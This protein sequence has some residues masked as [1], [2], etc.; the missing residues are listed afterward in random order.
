LTD[1]IIL[2]LNR[3]G[4]EEGYA[5]PIGWLIGV[6]IIIILA[7]IAN[8]VVKRI[9][10]KILQLVVKGSKSDWDD[11]ILKRKVFHRLANLAPAL[12]IYF[13]APMF[14]AAQDWIQRIT[15]SGMALIF[16]LSLNAFAN[17]VVDI[18]NKYEISQERPIKGVVQII[19]ILAY[20]LGAVFI[21]ATLMN[22]SPWVLLS[23]IGA[24]TAILLLIF[25]DSILGFVAGMQL[26]ANRM[27]RL[28]D[29]IEMPKYGADG[30]V[31]DITLTTVKVQNWDKTISTIP[32]YA[33]ITDSFKNWRGM[34]E[35]GGR[36]IKRAIY[37]DMNSIK[38]CNRE[39]LDRFEKI[40]YLRDYIKNKRKEIE[41]YNIAHKVDT[42]TL[43][44]GRNLTNIGTFRA[45]I[46]AYLKNHPKI[47][48]D[49]TFLIR[50][51]QPMA[52]GLPIE[53]Y[54][55]SS[56]QVWAN[57]ESIQADIFDHILS[58]VPEFDL[59]VFQN[60]TGSDF[61]KLAGYG[62]INSGN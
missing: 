44:N 40:Q 20:A 27:V 31:I 8:F 61:K 22:R 17:A 41:E 53:I 50:H 59:R 51:L 47:N 4:L 55:F 9:F 6:A 32:T 45:Y 39:M 19:M 7:L 34:S 30:D 46:V 15:V 42:S 21:I 1:R 62:D 5:E 25:R 56:D 58:V 36:R 2:W 43:V 3:L 37:I 57:Y 13:A 23:G 33:L 12:V 16:L 24:M 11:I 26:S 28:G 52:T 54:V 60:P 29:W 35:S 49:M 38:F 48:Q 14:P 10:L 18:Y